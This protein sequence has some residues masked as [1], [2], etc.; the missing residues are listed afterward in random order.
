MNK[1]IIVSDHEDLLRYED[2]FE[3]IS[4]DTFLKKYLDRPENI[5]DIN[6][7]LLHLYCEDE[8]G[9]NCDFKENITSDPHSN[10]ISEIVSGIIFHILNENNEDYM[11]ELLNRM[12]FVSQNPSRYY[13]WGHYFES[14]GGC[15]IQLDLEKQLKVSSIPKYD[16][17]LGDSFKE[18]PNIFIESVHSSLRSAFDSH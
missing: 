3:L 15:F 1:N 4:S 12:R 18:N 2:S 16:L 17:K 5:D 14:F 7:I 9:Q 11:E 13:A 8:M 6:S 10:R